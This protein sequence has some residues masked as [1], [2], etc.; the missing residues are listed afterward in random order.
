MSDFTF[1]LRALLIWLLFGVTEV[2]LGILRLR[3]LNRRVG[4]H[5]ARQIGVG[6]SCLFIFGITYITLPWSGANSVADMITLGTLWVCLMLAFD[7]AVGRIVFHFPWKRIRTDFDFRR[8]NL[9]GI[10][11]GFVFAAPLI[12]GALLGK[13]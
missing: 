6:V 5:R 10:G 9:L 11:M 3:L 13:I 2:L 7:L 12:A 1:I 4:D 8:G